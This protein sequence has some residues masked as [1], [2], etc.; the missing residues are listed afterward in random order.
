MSLGVGC[1]LSCSLARSH[2][3]MHDGPI[4][5]Q[6]LASSSHKCLFVSPVVTPVPIAHRPSIPSAYSAARLSPSAPFPSDPSQWPRPPRPRLRIHSGP[7]PIG[8]HGRDAVRRLVCRQ[9]RRLIRFTVTSGVHVGTHDTRGGAA[10]SGVAPPRS[11]F[12][13]PIDT[14]TASCGGSVIGCSPRTS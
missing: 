11:K 12:P 3:A 7:L 10:C 14:H 13:C 2:A 9:Y 5:G 1:R 6:A 4:L 8:A